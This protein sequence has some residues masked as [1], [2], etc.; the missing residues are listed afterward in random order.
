M[1][2]PGADMGHLAGIA[3]EIFEEISSYETGNVKKTESGS[4]QHISKLKLSI[5]AGLSPFKLI[6]GNIVSIQDDWILYY[7]I[8]RKNMSI[9]S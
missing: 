4:I 2:H 5:R 1:E 6:C 8:V 7:I 9:A 3:M